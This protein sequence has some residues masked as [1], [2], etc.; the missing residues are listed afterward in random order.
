[1]ANYIT[2]KQNRS[3]AY[4]ETTNKGY[5][6]VVSVSEDGTTCHVKTAWHENK[7][8]I[9]KEYDLPTERVAEDFSEVDEMVVIGAIE[10]Q[11]LAQT[12]WI[13][14]S[15][16][17]ANHIY[18]V[19]NNMSSNCSTSFHI[20]NSNNWYETREF[21]HIPTEEDAEYP[22][23][24]MY[25]NN[26]ARTT[27]QEVAAVVRN[28]FD[29]GYAFA[30]AFIVIPDE[31]FDAVV[32]D[33][34]QSLQ[35][36]YRT[37]VEYP[38]E[39]KL[40]LRSMTHKVVVLRHENKF[41]YIT[42]I[43]SDQ[44]IFN[45]TIFFAEQIGRPLSEDAKA[46]LLARDQAAYSAAI[47]A[48]IDAVLAGM[49]ERAKLK[50]FTEFGGKFSGMLIKPLQN[51]VEQCRRDYENYNTRATDAFRALQDANAKLF[52]AEHG[53]ENGEDEF[54]E[55]VTAA[56]DNIVSINANPSDERINICVR[57]FLTYWDDDLWDIVRKSDSRFKDMANWQK[58]L[59][60]EIF[61][62]RTIKLLFEQKFALDT[63][64][65]EA[66]NVD[67]YRQ[68]PY[69]EGTRGLRN[70]H[71]AYYNCWGTHRGYIRDALTR[72]DYVQAY[73][74]SVACISGV[75][76]SDSPVMDRFFR[77]FKSS[78][79]EN[80]PCLYVV[81]TGKYMTIKEYK[82]LNKGKGWSV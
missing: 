1:M 5:Y 41:A 23:V 9:N 22:R 49:T 56:R 6:E 52:Y 11:M 39:L 66:R 58:L 44:I 57:T 26:Y 27:G 17:N 80:L 33:A 21:L 75:T 14:R 62:D 61:K 24:N 72:A 13:V 43:K 18:T 81:E 12:G 16:N 78:D 30:E 54:I 28:A 20:W 37:T 79:F 63:Y 3:F 73:S 32:A 7:A 48:N 4:V 45:S 50:M 69:G 8:Y 55:L 19:R 38:E 15:D 35:E 10:R 40:Q 34:I 71:I 29:Y 42:N 76:L 47:Y 2:C 64:N 25:A 74:Q 51:A 60:D 70:P 46:A 53:I 31:N 82:E 68:D 77:Y 59:L 67:T 65:R 36:D